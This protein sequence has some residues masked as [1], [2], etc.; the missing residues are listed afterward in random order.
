MSRIATTRIAATAVL[1]ALL[2]AA[3]RPARADPYVLVEVGLPEVAQVEA[4]FSVGRLAL[5]A[6]AGLL[7]L[8][9]FVG[10]SAT[11][12]VGTMRDGGLPRHA[13]LLGVHAM[14]EPTVDGIT[15]HGETIAAYLG[16]RVGY[17]FV[18]AGGFLLR[19]ELGGVVYKQVG[20]V[21]A[22]PTFE[23][24]FGWHF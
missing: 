18:S 21:E 5:G 22:G 7:L 19:L 13:L 2:V 24:S 12:H 15:G 8:G 6:R 1:V 3:A 11:Y 17:G 14:K 16:G 20:G 23:A 9:T 10:G 4:G